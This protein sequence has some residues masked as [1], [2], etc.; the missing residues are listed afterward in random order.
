MILPSLFNMLSNQILKSDKELVDR[1][2]EV[3]KFGY[4]G[5]HRELLEES[6]NRLEQ[7][8]TKSDW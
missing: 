7:L 1:L 6:A 8:I 4:I 5:K 2:R 3:A